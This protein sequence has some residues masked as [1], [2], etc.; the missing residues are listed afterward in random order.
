MIAYIAMSNAIGSNHRSTPLRVVPTD[1]TPASSALATRRL[2]PAVARAWEN[3]QQ[4]SQPP[5]LVPGTAWN[6]TISF[7]EMK[8]LR[9]NPQ[10]LGHTDQ[11][12]RDQDLELVVTQ[13]AVRGQ[14]LASDISVDRHLSDFASTGRVNKVDRHRP[15]LLL[16]Q[17]LR[18]FGE[19][20]LH[21][22]SVRVS[23]K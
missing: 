21:E 16:E 1:V 2:V 10:R 12:R 11:L 23:G 15:A 13:L 22:A 8:P 3:G 19:H 18:F 7:F 14:V 4:T 20:D 6:S 17:L 5:S 9:D